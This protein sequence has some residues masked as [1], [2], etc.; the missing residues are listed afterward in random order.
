MN[1][2][3]FGLLPVHGIHF[4]IL[5]DVFFFFFFFSFFVAVIFQVE[6]K[7]DT[8]FITYEKNP[9]EA[10]QIGSFETGRWSLK[11]FIYIANDV[12]FSPKKKLS[13]LS[14]YSVFLCF[15][16]ISKKK[17]GNAV[18]AQQTKL[19]LGDLTRP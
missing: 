10:V 14:K 4:L 11:S 12:V 1:G 18:F 6:I 3:D 17:N 8:S 5:T 7:A 2:I 13:L 16:G 9:T 15:E 19:F